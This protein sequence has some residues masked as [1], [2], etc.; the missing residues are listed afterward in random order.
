MAPA[1]SKA[2]H[3][4]CAATS[5]VPLCPGEKIESP[6]D[7]CWKFIQCGSIPVASPEEESYFDYANCLAHFDSIGEHR[8]DLSMACIEVSTCDQRYQ[9]DC[10]V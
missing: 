3:P 6:E 9:R 2:L 1:T 8:S 5:G 10:L 7:A 4:G